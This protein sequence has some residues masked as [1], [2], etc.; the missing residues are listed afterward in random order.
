MF[1]LVRAVTEEKE[2]LRSK[3]DE[4]A[5]RSFAAV[6]QGVDDQFNLDSSAE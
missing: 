2:K 5:P 3:K 1:V 6:R 4:S